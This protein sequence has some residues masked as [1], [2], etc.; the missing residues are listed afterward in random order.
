M[1]PA[2]YTILY[3]AIIAGIRR[4]CPRGCAHLK[5]FGLGGAGES[6]VPY[7]LN[8]S[9]HREPSTPIDFITIH[10]YAGAQRNGSDNASAYTAFFTHQENFINSIANVRAVIAASDYP[11]ILIDADEGASRGRPSS[12]AQP[13]A[14]PHAFSPPPN[15]SWRHPSRRQ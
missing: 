14:L 6:Y 4:W 12:I 8:R 3:D 15:P 5:Y 2:F 10:S 1:T 13:P 9:N 7:F 11:D